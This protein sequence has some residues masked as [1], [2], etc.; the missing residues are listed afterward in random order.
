MPVTSPED[1]VNRL[2]QRAREAQQMGL[3][4]TAADL[5]QAANTLACLAWRYATFAWPSARCHRLADAGW[6]DDSQGSKFWLI[7]G[8]W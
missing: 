1:C 8:L 6:P 4:A 3:C 5:R 7:I 2:N